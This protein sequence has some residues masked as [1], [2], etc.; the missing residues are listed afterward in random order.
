MSELQPYGFHGDKYLLKTVD[1]IMK[2]ITNFIETG[3]FV[4]NTANYVGRTYS[5]VSVNSCELS[6][7]MYLTTVE[8]TKML[9]NVTIHHSDSIAFLN[10]LHN[11]YPFLRDKTNFYF[12]DAH[13]GEDWPLQ[14]E[15]KFITENLSS[16]V[17]LVDDAKVPNRP[18]FGFDSYKL[19]D[20]D[21]DLILPYMSKLHNYYVF[22]P[23]YTEHTSTFHP[24]RGYF[25][26]VYNVSEEI[27]QPMLENEYL[28][29]VK[30]FNS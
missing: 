7:D 2:R 25:F 23:N 26:F 29:C 18:E 13:G 11:N 1:L 8:N 12:L 30:L 19:G 15:V 21:L 17:V 16:A 24:L 4:G 10:N 5:H 27:L 28:T 22:Y 20:C 6:H 3:T 14:G 9:D